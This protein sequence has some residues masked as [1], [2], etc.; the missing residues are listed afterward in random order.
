M[1]TGR[2]MLIEAVGADV[3]LI[4]GLKGERRR[5]F[6]LWERFR[7]EE[8][9]QEEGHY[10]ACG[11]GWQL[12][13]PQRLDGETFHAF[14][15]ACASFVGFRR[16]DALPYLAT[17]QALSERYR[18]T[19]FDDEVVSFCDELVELWPD[20]GDV[21]YA[22]GFVHRHRGR[23]ELARDDFEAARRL[24]SEFAAGVE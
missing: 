24:G 23:A 4:V 9:R 18:K 6:Y 22:R 11:E 5:R 1:T 14:R 15:R 19:G 12:V 2:R 3:Y 17:L 7:V 13:P 21:R 16:I 20:N 8:V 10:F